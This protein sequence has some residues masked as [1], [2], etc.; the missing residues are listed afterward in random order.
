[1]TQE[2]IS[3]FKRSLVEVYVT[4]SPTSA[5]ASVV[6]CNTE[7]HTARTQRDREKRAGELNP[8]T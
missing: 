8:G 2:P 5:A 3:I 7:A 6:T 1:M 4:G